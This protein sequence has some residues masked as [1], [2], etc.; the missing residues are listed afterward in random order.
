MIFTVEIDGSPILAFEAN[1]ELEAR[2]MVELDEF[3][4]DLALVR[5]NGAIVYASKSKLI[6]RQASDGEADTY[7]YA[8]EVNAQDDAT[9]FVFLVHVDGLILHVLD[10]G[11]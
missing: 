9:K 4:D 1:S 5:S 6:T 3:R 11:Q 8:S 10:P 2:A 7:R